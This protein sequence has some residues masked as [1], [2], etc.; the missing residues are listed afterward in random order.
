MT[1]SAGVQTVGE[2]TGL[3]QTVGPSQLV[4]INGHRTVSVNFEPPEDMT[5]DEALKRVQ[6][7]VEPKVR[8]AMAPKVQLTYAGTANDLHQALR[9]MAQ[10]FLLA[11]NQ[12]HPKA[13]LSGPSATA[14]W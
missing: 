10:N 4:R 12:V 1:P 3:R 11:S 13:A 9:S 14:C 2:L 5:L 8:T 6:N 7:V